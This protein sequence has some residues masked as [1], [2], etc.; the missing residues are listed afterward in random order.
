MKEKGA[1]QMIEQK[2]YAIE[3]TGSTL[4]GLVRIRQMNKRKDESNAHTADN[5]SP[6][7]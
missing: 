7:Q 3:N 6:T 1:K 4:T 2:G 5:F